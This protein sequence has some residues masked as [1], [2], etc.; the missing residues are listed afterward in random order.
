MST[1]DSLIARFNN[2]K[3]NS[4]IIGRKN[5][6]SNLKINIIIDNTVKARKDDD[7][8]FLNS[9]NN[10]RRGDKRGKK[11]YD[12]KNNNK[13]EKIQIAKLNKYHEEKKKLKFWL[14]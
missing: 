1:A 13:S 10:L 4:F 6:I 9:K 14:F 11:F 5:K 12:K 8:N 3:K 2:F 7:F